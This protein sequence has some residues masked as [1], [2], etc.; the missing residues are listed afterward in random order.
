MKVTIEK[1]YRKQEQ[2]AKGPYE[3]IGLKTKEYGE[4]WLSGFGNRTTGTWNDGDVVEIDV[5]K[6]DKVNPKNGKPYLNFKT[7]APWVTRE[8][9]S[10]LVQEVE[11]LKRG[12][13][14]EA[15]INA[16]DIP[17]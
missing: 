3:R 2:G 7:P 9:F 13:A 14:K 15:E 1:V 4:E 16:D 11:A 10:A 6:S 12:G 5:I 17:F 8:E